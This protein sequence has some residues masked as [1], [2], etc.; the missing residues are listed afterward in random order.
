VIEARSLTK[1]FGDKVA[2]ERAAFST[3]RMPLRTGLTTIAIPA[4][5]RA[6]GLKSGRRHTARD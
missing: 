5:R 6:P 4:S 1:K 3:G 2:A